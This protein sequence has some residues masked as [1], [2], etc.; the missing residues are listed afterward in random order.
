MHCCMYPGYLFS[1][2]T[3]LDTSQVQLLEVYV[4]FSFQ[5]IRTAD[6]LVM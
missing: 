2:M 1:G 3:I 6:L 5:S 4:F